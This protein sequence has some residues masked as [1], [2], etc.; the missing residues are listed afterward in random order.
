MKSPSLVALTASVALTMTLAAH[1]QETPA[2]EAAPAAG[3]QCAGVGLARWI[4]ENAEGSDISN[5]EAPLLSEATINPDT[6]TVYGF[7]VS[8]DQPVRVEVAA[9]NGDPSVMLLKSSGE[10]IM[11]NDDYGDSLNSRLITELAPGDYCIQVSS[12]SSEPIQVKT[13]VSREDQPELFTVAAPREIATCS[14][15][16]DAIAWGEGALALDKG[17][18]THSLPGADVS[19]LRFVLNEPTP[20]TLR[21]VS[22]NLDPTVVL[23]DESGNRI[24][25]NDDADGTDAR[26]DFPNVLG[27]GKYCLGVMAISAGE[28]EITVSA[29]KLDLENYMKTAYRRGEIAPPADSDYPVE[30]I[31][32]AEG[33]KVALLGG[34][35]HWSRFELD[36]PTVVIVE[37]FGQI[38]GVDTKIAL[39]APNGSVAAENDDGENG[40]D[41]AIG[42]V[43]LQPGTY[44]LA[45]T[46]ISVLDQAGAPIRPVMLVFD[47]FTRPE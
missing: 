39:F 10:T 36:Q 31:D 33:R 18:V 47:R 23:F 24:G 7:K 15:T 41:S 30:Q 21:A 32:L 11:D 16:S 27:A 37:A 43:L 44:N 35:A 12:L 13:Q 3:P 1:A 28:G 22:R 5:A 8:A 19:Y 34:T 38:V 45:L 42:P 14:G 40:T 6:R 25:E 2:P 4:G 17:A 29:E 26:L 20:L 9:E 46:N